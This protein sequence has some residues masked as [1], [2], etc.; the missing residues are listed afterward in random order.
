MYRVHERGLAGAALG[1]GGTL[2][3]NFGRAVVR[4]AY[5]DLTGMVYR[6]VKRGVTGVRRPIR[7]RYTSRRRYGVPK[8]GR[9]YGRYAK[10]TVKRMARRRR[11]PTYKIKPKYERLVDMKRIQTFKMKAY[12]ITMSSA[13]VAAAVNHYVFIANTLVDPVDGSEWEPAE[14]PILQTRFKKYRIMHTKVKYRLEWHGTPTTFSYAPLTI[15]V[16][17]CKYGDEI[18]GDVTKITYQKNKKI[19]HWDI[20]GGAAKRYIEF[21]FGVT[22]T[23]LHPGQ[24]K[25]E[26]DWVAELN[27]AGSEPYGPVN[28]VE[29]NLWLGQPS[30]TSPLQNGMV[31]PAGMITIHRWITYKVMGIEPRGIDYN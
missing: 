30:P 25:N 11:R 17:N 31:G 14:L 15:I 20:M 27:T 10:Y 24:P 21:E 22:P 4:K 9:A 29:Q 1:L 6:R 19:L 28:M 18:P 7:R 26:D 3:Y 8:Y 2:A 12:K 13:F 5:S 16:Y 23:K